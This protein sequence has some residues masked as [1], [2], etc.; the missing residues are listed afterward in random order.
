[1]TAPK[2][3]YVSLMNQYGAKGTPFLFM[4]DFEQLH[5]V[6][7]PV[8]KA[9][10]QGI[11]FDLKGTKNFAG[12]NFSP[13]QVFS[14]ANPKKELFFKK[15]P[16]SFSIY[17]KAFE[18]VQKHLQYGN[19][20]LVNL[21][22]PTEIRT[23]LSF[24][25][26]FRQSQAPYKLLFR[27]KFVLFSPESF[28][29]IR[30]GKI[31]TFPMKGTID[32]DLPKASEQI[33]ANPK[34]FAEHATIVDLLRNDLSRVAKKVSVKRF[35]YLDQIQTNE[36]NLLQVSS[37]I[38]GVLPSNYNQELGSIFAKL[39]PAGSVSGA[40]KK[41]TLEIIRQAEGRPRGFY[42]GIFGY[43]DGQNLDSAVMIRFIE[44][45]NEQLFFRSGGGITAQSDLET[46]YAELIQKVYLPIVV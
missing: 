46:E 31:S 33:L 28:V 6:V 16:I 8:E 15:T 17:K 18:T 44:R 43:F 14:L 32:A 21:T 42:T 34:E 29:Q 41:K 37:E 10:E 27:D 13:W 23:N 26:I 45:Q 4:I 35:R 39:L 5:S 9:A 12:E 7:L 2:P 25:E 38:E 30:N 36:K 24:E 20:F 3:N 1:M 11:F 22:F 40:P 19:S